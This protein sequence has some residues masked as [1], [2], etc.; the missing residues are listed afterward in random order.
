MINRSTIKY[1]LKKNLPP[2]LFSGVLFVWN[3]ILLACVEFLDSL[4]AKRFTT[5]HAVTLT[6]NKKTFSL[7]ISP[8]NGFIDTYIY[9]YGVYEPF[10][11]DLFSKY[12]HK[13][14]TFVDIGTNIGQHSIYAATIVGES[15][16]VYSFEPIPF[17]Y[18]QLQDSIALNKFESIIHAKNSALGNEEST[19]TLHISR[20]NV[21]G[22]SL[23]NQE[24]T[25]E[26]LTVTIK[27]GDDELLSLKKIDVIKIDV[28]GY[29]YEVLL[30]SKQ[31]LMHHKPLIFLEFSGQFYEKNTDHYGQKILSLLHECNYALYDI[32]DDMKLISDDT[33]FLKLFNK[34]KKQTNLLCKPQG[35]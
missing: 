16:S 3:H 13:G 31:T 8:K 6:H 1:N 29:E 4:R 27:K 34:D 11:L 22:S 7:F 24:G 28:E 9:L 19:K 33:S 14:M 20:N 18:Q 30:G 35:K 10:M 26:E 25:T 32:E 5:Y 2:F 23:V 21:G 12:L 17:I 15:G